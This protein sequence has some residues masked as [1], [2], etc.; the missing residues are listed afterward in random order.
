MARIEPE[1]QVVIDQISDHWNRPIKKLKQRLEELS[2]ILGAGELS[3]KY[4]SI[5][6]ESERLAF[7]FD[8]FGKRA[9]DVREARQEMQAKILAR[10]WTA[11]K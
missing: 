3:E 6:N 1:L 10:R 4:R 5:A 2:F 8:H 7:L 11:K 9:L